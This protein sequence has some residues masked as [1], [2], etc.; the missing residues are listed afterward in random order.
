YWHNNFGHRMS[1]GCVNIN[2]TNSEWLYNWAN[3]GDPVIVHD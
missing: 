3:V 1:H 2:A